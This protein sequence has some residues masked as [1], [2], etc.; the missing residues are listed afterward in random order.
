MRT[1]CRLLAAA[2][3]ACA[4]ASPAAAGPDRGW[5]GLFDGK[6]LN[7]WVQ[8]GGKALYSAEDGIIVGTSVKGTPNSFLC[9]EED[10]ANFILEYEFKVDPRLNSG[11]QIRSQSLPE[12]K[13]GRV[14]GYQIEIDPS[15]RAWTAGIYDEGRRGWLCNLK[16]N[17]PARQAF[18]QNEWNHVRVEALGE[19]LKTWLNTVPAA[20]LTDDLTPSGFIGLQVHSTQSEEPMHVRWRNLRIIDLGTV[21]GTTRAV[22]GEPAEE[23]GAPPPP[24]AVV[25]LG[26]DNST[27][28][29]CS[30]RSRDAACP[31]Q[32]Q[33]GVMAAV[34]GTGSIETKRTCRD[35]RLHLEF[36][37]NDT[38]V[39]SG[40][41]S[42]NS[43]VYIHR[44]YEVQILNSYGREPGLQECAAIY[45]TKPPDVNA[46]RPAGQWQSYD[47]VFRSPRWDKHGKK[48]DNARISV[49]HNGALVH[50][51][52]EIP[53][54][55]GAG[56]PEGIDDGPIQLQD[57]GNPVRFRNIWLT[58]LR[59]VTQAATAVESAWNGMLNT[60][61]GDSRKPLLAIEAAVTAADAAGRAALESRFLQALQSPD[62][63]LECKRFICRMLR[64]LGTRQSVP[65]L[66]Q[67]LSDPEL[68]SMARFA[69]AA[70]PYDEVDDAL[71]QALDAE[72]PLDAR[73]GLINTIGERQDAQAIPQ[74]SRLLGDEAHEVN[75]AA[76]VAIGRSGGTESLTILR[77][78]K[79][80]DDLQ[81][82]RREALLHCARRLQ[83]AGQSADAQAV[84]LELT[85]PGTP[86]ATRIAAL[87][88]L[89]EAQGGRAVPLLLELIQGEEEDLQKAAGRLLVGIPGESVSVHAA[90]LLHALGEDGQLVLLAAL[91][92]RG[93][94]AAAPNVLGLLSSKREA[95]R[96]AA[97]QALGVLGDAR[98][99]NALA[100]M[101]AGDGAGAREA[102]DSLARL[103]GDGVDDALLML[104]EEQ[105]PEL[106]L[107]AVQALAARR[108]AEAPTALLTLA[109]ATTNGV[110]RM[111]CLKSLR[112]IG[113]AE[114]FRPT[115]ALLPSLSEAKE[116]QEARKTVTDLGAKVEDT[117]QRTAWL[118]EALRQAPAAARPELVS[119]L[120]R[121]GGDQ[122]RDV[123]VSELRNADG[124]VRYAA[125]KALADWSEPSPAPHLLEF[126]RGTDSDVHHVLAMRGYA[127]LLDLPSKRTEGETKALCEQ[128]LTVAR[129][130]QEKE[131][132][133]SVMIALKVTELKAG[134]KKT[135]ELARKG[136][137]VGNKVYTDRDYVFVKIPA[138]LG[139]ADHI[140]TA[141]NDKNSKTDAFLTF[142]ISKPA[143]VYVCYD[144]R[145]KQP[146]AWLAGWKKTDAAIETTDRACKLV[147]FERQFPAGK[148]EIGG[149]AAPGVGANYTAGVKS[150]Q[151]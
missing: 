137:V 79:V 63:T 97:T 46:C 38:P 146:P 129:R 17:E 12:Y 41:S 11:V 73:T 86:N 141:M 84:F 125:V 74:L 145:G 42:G 132:L 16:D 134:S 113:G 75:A 112:D 36:S 71:R 114:S 131:L 2:V 76:L 39:K 104:L 93:D 150:G 118:L 7:G 133:N 139:A 32:T 95:V 88:G 136:F 53:N 98:H 60:R 56:K 61:F 135:Y 10:Y 22:L 19:S 43:G 26:A 52:A 130:A 148:V 64:R 57:H 121:F 1:A 28:E 109:G 51:N 13:N 4:A 103:T 105:K 6:S 23:M 55:T 8:R 77:E 15:A 25:L 126:A 89:V 9:T 128:A 106:Q 78:T 138:V 85:Q 47:I 127:R 80:G 29:W 87:S 102:A 151:Q 107:A 24:D 149:N 44:R 91:A 122:A 50:D 72:L 66:A 21:C 117:A 140:K 31:W 49:S 62:A 33:D 96:L 120:G 58:D 34:P 59:T 35:F 124:K 67:L 3:L 116:L 81:A 48:T 82:A 54:K 94:K 142:T 111:A 27:A 147:L 115:L 143:I 5:K 70:M 123:L 108:C 110:V 83:E 30:A 144:S 45:K 90:E 119:V 101:T 40:Q 14:H 68:S 37:V 69:L 92:S 18:K 20:A 99:V 65:L 100:G